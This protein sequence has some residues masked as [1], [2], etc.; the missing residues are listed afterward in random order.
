L[1]LQAYPNLC[2]VCP[3]VLQ[4]VAAVE[5]IHH[6]RVWMSPTLDEEEKGEVALVATALLLYKPASIDS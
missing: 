6:G 3:G 2:S 1:L 4:L 5:A